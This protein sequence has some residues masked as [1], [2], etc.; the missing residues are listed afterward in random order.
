MC[1]S[2][3]NASEVSTHRNHRP[4][5]HE[6]GQHPKPV[7][8]PFWEGAVEGGVRDW[9]EVVSKLRPRLVTAGEKLGYMLE[10]PQVSGATAPKGEVAVTMHPVMRTISREVASAV[11]S[12]R[13][14]TPQRLHA[15]LLERP[16][17]EPRQE[18]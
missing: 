12:T 8:Q 14:L 13:W 16:F 1:L 4:S 7:A 11:L 15:E 9:G 3:G 2:G 10:N 17:G 5:H 18:R 6:S